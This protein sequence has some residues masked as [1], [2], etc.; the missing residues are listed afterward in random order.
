[1]ANGQAIQ[2]MKQII[3]EAKAEHWQKKLIKS[4]FRANENR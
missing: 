1:L 4:N 3:D 2:E